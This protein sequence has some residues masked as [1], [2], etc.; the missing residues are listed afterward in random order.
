[1]KDYVLSSV[2]FLIQ[3]YNLFEEELANCI[4]LSHETHQPTQEQQP[5]SDEEILKRSTENPDSSSSSFSSFNSQLTPDS[6][7]DDIKADIDSL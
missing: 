2:E 6:H 5:P 4:P 3:Y 7:T 1:M